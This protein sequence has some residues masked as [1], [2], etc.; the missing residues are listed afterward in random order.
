MGDVATINSLP[1]RTIAAICAGDLIYELVLLMD[2]LQL[3]IRCAFIG[4]LSKRGR[5]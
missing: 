5:A 2:K 4:V 1:A 3:E